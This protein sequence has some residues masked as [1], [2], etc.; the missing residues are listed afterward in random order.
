MALDQC[1][2][3]RLI[4]N[5]LKFKRISIRHTTLKFNCAELAIIA[6]PIKLDSNLMDREKVAAGRMGAVMEKSFFKEEKAGVSS[7]INLTLAESAAL[8]ESRFCVPAH[9]PKFAARANPPSVKCGSR[10]GREFG[11][12]QI[13]SS[14]IN[15]CAL[16]EFRECGSDARN[17]HPQRS[18]V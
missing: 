12:G 15:D 8:N 2:P 4:W 17:I 6:K 18:Q 16:A 3:T 9:V 1:R 10:G 11:C 5:S 7:R 13:F 14:R